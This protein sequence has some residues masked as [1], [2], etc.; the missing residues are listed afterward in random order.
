MASAPLASRLDE[1]GK[2]WRGESVHGV[3]CGE[4][5]ASWH[6]D[7]EALFGRVRDLPI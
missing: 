3:L 1:G 2:R 4:E 6:R 7:D 5:E